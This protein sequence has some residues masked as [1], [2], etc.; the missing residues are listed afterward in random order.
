MSHTILT[1]ERQKLL[2]QFERWT[3]SFILSPSAIFITSKTDMSFIYYFQKFIYGCY[4]VPSLFF[5]GCAAKVGLGMSCESFHIFVFVPK[6][7][8]LTNPTRVINPIRPIPSLVSRNWVL[9]FNTLTQQILME[10]QGKM[11][12][13]WIKAEMPM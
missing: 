1:P 10:R 11:T 12:H 13:N 7:L 4:F 3:I 9:G 8:N 2:P 5:L 6:F